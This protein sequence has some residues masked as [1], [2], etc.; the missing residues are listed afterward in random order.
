[1]LLVVALAGVLRF[2]D[3]TPPRPEIDKPTAAAGR[4]NPAPPAGLPD[5]ASLGVPPAPDDTRP[6]LDLGL[7]LERYQA[8]LAAS[9]DDP[10]LLDNIG[11][12]LVALNRPSEAV[13]FIERAVAIE[14]FSLTA[15]FNL[16]VAYARCGRLSEAVDLYGALAQTGST[17]PRIHHNLG[18]ALRQLGRNGQ[19]AE[20]FGRATALAPG[21]APGWLG[22]A[23]SLEAEGR[24]AEAAAALERYLALEP[25]TP[26][27]DNVRAR[28]ARLR[29]TAPPDA[30]TAASNRCP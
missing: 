7:A 11:Q 5:A 30:G 10:Q 12:I 1:V 27:A 24:G 4:S 3:G 22:L 14:P 21:Q 13:P 29:G 16:A 26:D 2:W 8:A 9:P 25:D 17:D 15:R 20:A 18:L 28:I 23:L 6:P 19:A